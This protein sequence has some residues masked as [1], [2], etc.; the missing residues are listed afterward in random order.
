MSK[1]SDRPRLGAKVR[2]LR[3]K[4]GLTQAKLAEELGISASYLNLIEN[5]RRPLTAE[6]LIKVAQR[7][8]V[9]LADFASEGEARLIGELHEV[10][11]D[12]I[13]DEVGLTT[14]DVRELAAAAPRA[15]QAV[16]TLYRSYQGARESARTLA[17]RLADEGAFEVERP[18]LPSEEVSD[19]VERRGNHFPAL[20]E[21]AEALH[22]SCG[23]ADFNR[24]ER[25][26]E[27]L[28]AE[29]GIVVQVVPGTD[30]GLRRYDPERRLITLSEVL[31]PRSR[32]FQLAHQIGLITARDA[33]DEVAADAALTTDASRALC[34]VALGNYF[35]AAVL[36]PYGRFARAARDARYDIEVLGHRFRVSFEQVCHR[37]TT[38][39]RPGDEG[40][41]FHFLRVDI[42]GNISKRF[43]GSGIRFAR[44]SGACP[45]WNVFKAFL[46]PGMVTR[47]LSA[48]PDGTTYFCVAKTVRSGMG[49]FHT[50]PTLYALGLG[51]DV[52]HAPKIVYAD[53]MDLESEQATVPVGVTC[54]LCERMDCAQRAFP[55]VQRALEVDEDVRGLSF[56]APPEIGRE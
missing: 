10:F 54:R 9:D 1:T 21:A 35:A 5:D 45:R 24:Y 31:P 7:F 17:G 6:L 30:R 39:G 55:P 50:Q 53:G 8:G 15:A 36:M 4:A 25:L 3:R 51:C 13:F 2:A 42:A 52:R 37:L 14:G 43:A 47:Q 18:L 28:E 44:Y 23:L 26:R 27:F 19:L 32:H 49:G 56:Y 20:E 34:R 46:T 11:G 48:M 12:P 38:L 41:P 29:H 22:E 40:I 33:I 16:V